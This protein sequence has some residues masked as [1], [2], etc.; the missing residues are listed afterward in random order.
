[1]GILKRIVAFRLTRFIVV[2]LANTAINFAILNFAYYSLHR[3][4]L[5]SSLLA[6]S[7]AVVI[8]FVLNRNFVFLD[9]ERPAKRLVLFI[10][11]TLS[12][13]LLIQNSIYSIGILLLRHHEF[14][15]IHIIHLL[16][17]IT[18]SPSFI[19]INL[20]NA[21]ASLFVMIW[22]YNGYRIFVFNAERHGNE[23][24]EAT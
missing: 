4:K 2:G 5:V 7:C 17:Q 19:D 15:L 11:V 12:G 22:N 21:V 18:L 24:T 10:F 23:L 6:T 9:K 16:T 3:S 13:V 14:G 8:S 20:S 1:M